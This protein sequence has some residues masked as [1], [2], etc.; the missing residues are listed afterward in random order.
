MTIFVR[1]I[2][3]SYLWKKEDERIMLGNNILLRFRDPIAIH[4]IMQKTTYFDVTHL[5]KNMSLCCWQWYRVIHRSTVS[6]WMTMGS[7]VTRHKKHRKYH[8][9]VSSAQSNPRHFPC[10]VRITWHHM[11]INPSLRLQ[12]TGTTMWYHSYR[13]KHGEYTIKALI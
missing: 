11:I 5:H 12:M 9:G 7:L 2:V 13:K 8:D 4:Q 1:Q 6:R 10:S 3:S